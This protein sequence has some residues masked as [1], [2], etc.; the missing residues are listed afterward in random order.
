MG[1]QLF[2]LPG[3]HCEEELILILMCF[4]KTYAKESNKTIKLEGFLTLFL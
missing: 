2:V 1:I 4:I 3:L